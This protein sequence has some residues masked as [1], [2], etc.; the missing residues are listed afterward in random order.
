MVQ[1]NI[2]AKSS[3]K[4]SYYVCCRLQGAVLIGKAIKD[5]ETKM[6]ISDDV[7]EKIRRRAC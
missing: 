1:N 7:A 2:E 3:F 4:V 5:V 6:Y